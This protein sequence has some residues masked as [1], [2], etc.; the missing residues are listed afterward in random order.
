MSDLVAKRSIARATPAYLGDPA[1]E[2]DQSSVQ[3]S[4]LSCP[5][6]YQR[7]SWRPI[8]LIRALDSRST[9]SRYAPVL[10]KVRT[11][12]V[13]AD[14]SFRSCKWRWR[15]LGFQSLK[16]RKL[17]NYKI[18][19]PRVGHTLRPPLTRFSLEL[20]IGARNHK[21]RMM[22]LPDGQKVLR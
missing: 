5:E 19:H 22:G 15:W 14:S 17:E 3:L 1:G 11:F 6:S 16:Y 2:P 9:S 18:S 4:M 8:I 20:S 13:P 21:T 10:H 7:T 12:H